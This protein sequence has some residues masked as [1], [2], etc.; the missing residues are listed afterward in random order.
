MIIFDCVFDEECT[1][2]FHTIFQYPELRMKSL[3][4]GGGYAEFHN[5]ILT[6][7]CAVSEIIKTSKLTEI[8]LATLWYM[9]NPKLATILGPLKKVQL[10][11]IL[12]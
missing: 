12:I 9:K 7:S 5:T 1:E 2:S 11:N 8:S 4:I 3:E 10:R 6:V